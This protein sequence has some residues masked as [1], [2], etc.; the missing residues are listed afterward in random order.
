MWLF[1]SY[2]RGSPNPQIGSDNTLLCLCSNEEIPRGNS[3][4]QAAKLRNH[5]LSHFPLE[6]KLSADRLTRVIPM[7]KKD[8][9]L[10]FLFC[11][12]YFLP[13]INILWVWVQ[14]RENMIF[15]SVTYSSGTDISLIF[16]CGFQLILTNSR[17]LQDNFKWS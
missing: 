17:W 6:N 9:S 13:W 4:F 12:H 11:L 16:Y 8:L 2:E 3:W 14:K 15:F 10:S 7:N 1:G 5:R